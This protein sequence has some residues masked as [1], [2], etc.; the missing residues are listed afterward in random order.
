MDPIVEWA[1]NDSSN[2]CLECEKVFTLMNRKHHCR[3]CGKLICH[4]CS[5]SVEILQNQGVRSC[6][7]CLYL[8]SLR[9]RD[10]RDAEPAPIVELYETFQRHKK[11]VS[12]QLVKFN[13]LL[14]DLGARS[15]ISHQDQDYQVSLKLRK[16]LLDSFAAID[17]IA[18]SIK[19]LATKSISTQKLFNSIY[20][21]IVS[22]LQNNMFTLQLMPVIKDK[23]VEPIQNGAVLVLQET[24]KQLENSLQDAISRRKL[25]DAESIEI[26]LQDMKLELQ[27]LENS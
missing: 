18:K 16:E 15:N 19:A 11:G 3:L 7:S 8:L 17:H 6:T 12:S 25:E 24:I 21:S 4:S 14:M 10:S 1:P 9:K 20:I 23:Q 5:K 26:Q 27:L 22:W 2:R 13:A